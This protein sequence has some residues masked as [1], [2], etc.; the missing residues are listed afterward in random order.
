VFFILEKLK[1]LQTS[2]KK[3]RLCGT[4]LSVQSTA[5]RGVKMHV[6]MQDRKK[7]V[8]K[9]CTT[10]EKFLEMFAPSVV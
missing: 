9:E 5:P 2:N 3:S 4:K 1:Q 6:Q 8:L 7:V 10:S